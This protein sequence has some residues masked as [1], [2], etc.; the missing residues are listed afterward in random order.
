MHLRQPTSPAPPRCHSRTPDDRPSDTRVVG[1]AE[2]L[3]SRTSHSTACLP[4]SAST[5]L[6]S[7]DFD[8]KSIC[9]AP[10]RR[11]S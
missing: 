1:A 4:W 5:T 6:R 3:R 8:S 9:A 7:V 2:A 11:L 10:R